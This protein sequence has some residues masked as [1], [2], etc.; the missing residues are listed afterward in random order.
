MTRIALVLGGGVSLGSYIG[1]AVTEILEALARNESGG[2]VTIHVITGGSA[3]ALN[4]GLAARALA[5]NPT[6]VPWIEKAWVEA[7]DARQ[8]LNPGR[9]N[10][11]GALDATV[12][13]DLSR[14]LITAEPASDDSASA[15]LGTPLRVG[16]T[17]SNLHGVRYDFRYGFL[18][19]P[20]RAFGTRTYSDSID[21]ELPAG[22]GAKHEDWERLRA[23]AVASAAFPFAFPPRELERTRD[24]YP[25]ARL[26]AGEDPLR[27]WYVDGGLFDAAPLGLAKDLVE[28]D[29]DYRSQDW[30]YIVVEP[31]LRSTGT[32]IGAP[33]GAPDSVSSLA[34]HLARAVL[35]QGA[36]QDW[37][38][39][40]ELNA[41]LEILEALLKRLPEMDDRITDPD[42]LML[43]RYIGELAER[44]AEMKVAADPT[45]RL[46]QGADPA[47]DFL[48]R[49]MARIEADPR[50]SEVLASA[51]ARAG[52]SRLAKL[53]FVLEAASGLRDKDI[54]RLYLV[55]P[56]SDRELAGDYLGGFG[57]FLHR[58]WRAHDFAAGR[59]DAR[60]ML[61]TSLSDI[62]RYRPA[63]SSA[64]E[65]GEIAP[66]WDQVPADGRRRVEA[67]VAAEAD[68]LIAEFE[69]GAVASAFGWAWKPVVRRWITARGMRAISQAR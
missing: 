69:P 41:R 46:A 49:N 21:F 61:E 59:R 44:V 39:A 20:D 67:A 2:P 51:D 45:G 24:E 10:R 19:V 57:G 23:S 35:G 3:G 42:E 30:R 53:I 63:E 55:A 28:R 68:R 22:I 58:D 29:P 26:A 37:I 54:M 15:S 18:N 16:I 17:L 14:A 1:G 66:A 4:A 27:M 13:D 65:V 52:R 43:G 64:Y 12:L 6:V 9:N 32:D 50:Y 48:D 31:S 5:V 8:L 38:R 62:L 56:E 34:Q 60:R 7:A 40:N 33:T 25:G 47:G 11:L 36:A